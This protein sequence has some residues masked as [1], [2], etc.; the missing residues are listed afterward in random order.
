MVTFVLSGPS[1]TSLIG[2]ANLY[3]QSL[4]NDT[5]PIHYHQL[6]MLVILGLLDL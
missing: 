6:T 1:H 3:G 5:L 4:T 2:S